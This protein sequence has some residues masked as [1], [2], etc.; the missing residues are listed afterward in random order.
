MV[1]FLIWDEKRSAA[2]STDFPVIE[3]RNMHVW[4]WRLYSVGREQRW[5]VSLSTFLSIVSPSTVLLSALSVHLMPASIFPLVYNIVIHLRSPK[6]RSTP[7]VS[8]TPFNMPWLWLTVCLM[9]AHLMP[10]RA[11]F[12]TSLCQPSHSSVQ[13]RMTVSNAH[14]FFLPLLNF[15]HLSLAAGAVSCLF[16]PTD[17]YLYCYT[18]LGILVHWVLTFVGSQQA[19]RRC[20]F[21][22]PVSYPPRPWVWKVWSLLPGCTTLTSGASGNR[23][24]FPAKLWIIFNC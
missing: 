8:H 20:G 14:I 16:M 2:C 12:W 3:V 21:S 19:E 24:C 11:V 4:L 15:A 1:E 13:E 5:H 22:G 9:S 17:V 10:L 23:K 18:A 7:V 6:P